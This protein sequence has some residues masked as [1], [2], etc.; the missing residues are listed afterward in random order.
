M[1][2]DAIPL[3]TGSMNAEQYVAALAYQ[4]PAMR[5]RTRWVDL[6]SLDNFI[7][8]VRRTLSVAY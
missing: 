6:L 4:I 3:T 8:L 1:L 7:R 5:C 2:W